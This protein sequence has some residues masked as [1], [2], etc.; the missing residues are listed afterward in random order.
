MRWPSSAC[1]RRNRRTP[2]HRPP[3]HPPYRR[4]THSTRTAPSR[5]RRP[6]PRCCPTSR[7]PSPRRHRRNA[8]TT[9]AA[10][11]QRRSRATDQPKRTP[12]RRS[13]PSTCSSRRPWSP[14]RPSP[15][16]R[17]RG[18][19]N[20]SAFSPRSSGTSPDR[21]A[22]R[23]SRRSPA[24]PTLPPLWWS[25]SCRCCSRGSQRPRPSSCRRRGS[26]RIHV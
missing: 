19:Y 12:C 26:R 18:A 17:R 11:S 22:R 16:N 4:R 24:R 6:N 15:C 10:R 2:P 1:P 13:Y 20:T 5:L 9:F 8:C 14:H 21:R 25:S 3:L 23:C 7:R